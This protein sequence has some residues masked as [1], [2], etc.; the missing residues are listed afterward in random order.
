MSRAASGVYEP[1]GNVMLEGKNAIVTGSSRGTGKAIAL[2]MVSNGA[3]VVANC[4]S[5]V[6]SS[7]L[8]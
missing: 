7:S 8:I 1:G 5:R 4:R 3:N 2:D 6:T